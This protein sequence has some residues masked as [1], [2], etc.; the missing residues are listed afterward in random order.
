[1]GREHGQRVRADLVRR[2]AVGRDAVGAREHDVHLAA[3]HERAGGRVGQH[4]AGTPARSSSQAVSRAP[5]RSGRVSSTST[6]STRPRACASQI[7][8]SAVPTPPVASAPV[9]Q[10]VRAREPGGEQ[11]GAVLR[12]TATAL[13]LRLVDPPR[14]PGEGGGVLVAGPH[15]GDRP[16]Q[17]HGR[18]TRGEKRRRGRVEILPVLGGQ[19]VAVGGGDPDRRRA[20]HCQRANRLRDLCGRPALEVRDLVRQPALV[21]ERRPPRIRGGRSRQA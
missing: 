9:L 16:G 18:R 2:V 8:P 3:R 14:A 13:D 20:A 21:E 15:L 5:W 19:R 4:A 7:A 10:C 11:A 1:M 6:C 17:V 12:H